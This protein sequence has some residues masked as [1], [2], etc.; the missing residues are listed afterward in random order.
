TSTLL[1]RKS[2]LSCESNSKR[3]CVRVARRVGS[4]AA[5]ASPVGC[6]EELMRP[7][8][9]SGRSGS[10]QRAHCGVG[11]VAMTAPFVLISTADTDLLAARA[12]GA[13]WR[14][15]NPSRLTV[16]DLPGLLEGAALVLVRLLGGRRTW[17]DGLDAVLATGVP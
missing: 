17:P 8:Q 2:G 4:V 13:P 5:V 9:G 6:G 15:A 3:P 14:V 1:Y 11:E 7:A 16:E 10:T 12:S